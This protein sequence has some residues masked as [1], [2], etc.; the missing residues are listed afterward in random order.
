MSLIS[1]T[2]NSSPYF[3][4]YSP[5]T[6]DFLR[7][8]FRPGYAVQARELNQLQAIL[9]EQ[10]TRF[11]NSIYQ[12]GSPIVGGGTTVDTS[13]PQYLIIGNSYTGLMSAFVGTVITG[14][15]SGAVATVVAQ[16]KQALTILRL[17]L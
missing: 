17:L 12:E 6:K 7:V 16:P 5:E 11:G 2:L 4:D 10:V 13:T 14:S 15:T 8:L 3:D 9:Q 1:N